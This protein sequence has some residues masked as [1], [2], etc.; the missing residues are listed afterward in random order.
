MY[1]VGGNFKDS[2]KFFKKL[3][4]EDGYTLLL[5]KEVQR[6]YK[7]KYMN[8]MITFVCFSK[9]APSFYL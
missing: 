7:R 3:R 6:K 5:Q 8:Y 2:N 4:A 9:D 1:Y